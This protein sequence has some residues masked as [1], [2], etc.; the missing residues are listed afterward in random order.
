MADLQAQVL[1]TIAASTQEKTMKSYTSCMR[2][3]EAFFNEDPDA[4]RRSIF[5]E[6]TKEN[7]VPGSDDRI[8]PLSCNEILTYLAHKRNLNPSL[9]KIVLSVSN[10]QPLNIV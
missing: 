5:K 9:K 4:D 1:G 8:V 7:G 2:Q 6:Y 3:M 10:L